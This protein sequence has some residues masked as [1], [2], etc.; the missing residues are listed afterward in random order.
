M[1]VS[2]YSKSNEDS[3]GS[4]NYRTNGKMIEEVAW[5]QSGRNE[6]VVTEKDRY[7]H[8]YSKWQ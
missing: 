6:H 2:D 8:S 5:Y 3:Y 1:S 7:D 4:N